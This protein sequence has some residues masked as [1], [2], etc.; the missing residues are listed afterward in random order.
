MDCGGFVQAWQGRR[1]IAPGKNAKTI[2]SNI[3]SPQLE[4]EAGA[5]QETSQSYIARLESGTVHP[6]T[7]ALARVA[8][9]TGTR[10]RIDFEPMPAKS[11][12]RSAQRRRTPLNRSVRRTRR[13]ARQSNRR[14]IH[15]SMFRRRADAGRCAEGVKITRS[16]D[17]SLLGATWLESDLH[18]SHGPGSG[19]GTQSFADKWGNTHPRSKILATDLGTRDPFFAF[20]P[21]IR[22]II[23]TT[24]AVE[25]LNMSLRKITELRASFPTEQAALKLLYLALRNAAAK[26]NTA[27]SWAAALN[28]FTKL[29]EDRI[30]AA[31]SQMDSAFD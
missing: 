4:L 15:R 24:N 23:Y 13:R 25:S 8:S 26:W 11:L 18:R 12:R 5:A 29:W 9:A 2:K 20:A 27:K 19:A 7:A 10:L 31:R 3:Q 16:G 28:Q 1:T 14:M 17:G 21:K 22:K 30:R 6:S